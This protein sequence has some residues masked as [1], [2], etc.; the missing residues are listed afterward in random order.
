MKTGAELIAEERQE[1]IEKH[2]YNVRN[3]AEYYRNAELKNA[4]TYCLTLDEKYYPAGWGSLFRERIQM[5]RKKLSEKEFEIEMNS[6]AGAL[7]AANIDVLQ[8]VEKE[9]LIV[10]PPHD[11]KRPTP[12]A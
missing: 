2:G 8:T 9:R 4:A 7:L 10:K 3:D 12:F 5:K 11:P 6:I 1:Q